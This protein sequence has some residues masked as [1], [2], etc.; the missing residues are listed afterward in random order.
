M[1]EK[2]KNFISNSQVLNI[3]T[4]SSTIDLENKL[5]KKM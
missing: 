5:K 2:I 1:E 4:K 3:K